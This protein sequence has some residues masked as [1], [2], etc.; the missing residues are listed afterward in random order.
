MCKI[1]KIKDKF[2]SGEITKDEIAFLIRESARLERNVDYLG[3]VIES[4]ENDIDWLQ[5][6]LS[7][8]EST[9]EG[10]EEGN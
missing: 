10:F 5:A 3:C 6:E 4:L 1:Q 7:E 8:A 9:I 2:E